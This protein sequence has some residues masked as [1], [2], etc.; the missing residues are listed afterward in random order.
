L[1]EFQDEQQAIEEQGT[2]TTE[3]PQLVKDPITTDRCVNHGGAH[4]TAQECRDHADALGYPG[5]TFTELDPL[6]YRPAGCYVNPEVTPISVYFNPDLTSTEECSLLRQCLCAGAPTRRRTMAQVDDSIPLSELIKI[7]DQTY[8]ARAPINVV[9]HITSPSVLLKSSTL[10]YAQHEAFQNEVKVISERV[11]QTTFVDDSNIVAPAE[12]NVNYTNHRNYIVIDYTEVDFPLN[13]ILYIRITVK[14]LVEYVFSADDLETRRRLVDVTYDGAID[15]DSRRVFLQLE[16]GGGNN[17]GAVGS[18]AWK[19]G[20]PN[21]FEGDQPTQSKDSKEATGDIPQSVFIAAVVVMVLVMSPCCCYSCYHLYSMF[22]DH[23][24]NDLMTEKDMATRR[25]APGL[26]K[27]P[28]PDSTENR[29]LP[30]TTIYTSPRVD[31]RSSI[32]RSM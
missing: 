21:V 2:T 15:K 25:T 26:T 17:M 3:A 12:Y 22:S 8:D 9:T 32:Q 18:G 20:L 13:T 28:T 19:I 23:E 1:A 5:Y 11:S 29:S 30:V 14:V 27:S 6:D 31:T 24:K 10:I 7:G 4:G 16:G